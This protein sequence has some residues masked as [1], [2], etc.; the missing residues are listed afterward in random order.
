[1]L[2]RLWRYR[3]RRRSPCRTLRHR[4]GD[5]RRPFI[6]GGCGTTHIVGMVRAA[7]VEV[8]RNDSRFLRPGISLAASWRRLCV[9]C[10]VAPASPLGNVSRP[11]LAP[12]VASFFGWAGEGPAYR[13]RFFFTSTRYL[14]VRLWLP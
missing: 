8:A 9:V 5:P 10:A 4:S 14:R 7:G 11:G 6:P 12:G 3:R 13:Y 1:M 2:W